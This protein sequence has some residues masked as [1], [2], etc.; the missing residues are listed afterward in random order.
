MYSKMAKGSKVTICPSLHRSQ[1]ICRYRI[2]CLKL[3]PTTVAGVCCHPNS[4]GKRRSR[5]VEDGY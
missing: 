4:G 1:G 2:F 5:E 3:L